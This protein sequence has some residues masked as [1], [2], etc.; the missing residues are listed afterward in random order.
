[1]FS[2]PCLIL[3]ALCSGTVFWYRLKSQ[4]LQRQLSN[5]SNKIESLSLQLREPANK[6]PEKRVTDGSTPTDP[7]GYA[8][9]I[10][11]AT[12]SKSIDADIA[13]IRKAEAQMSRYFANMPGFA[14]TLH[15]S[16]SGHQGF[17]FAGPGIEDMY[18]L[19]P[20]EVRHD[21]TPM[22]DRIHPD[23]RPLIEEALAKAV[24]NS[25]P[26]QLEFRVRKPGS[27]ER[28][29]ECRT[30]PE[31]QSNGETL[32]HGVS[33]DITERKEAE[34]KLKETLELIGGVISAIPDL[35]FEVDAEGRYLNIWTHTPE[36]L[37]AQR[38]DLLGRTLQE[39]MSPESAA[40]GMEALREAE[41]N[42]LSFG[43]VIRLDLPQGE[44]WF[45]LSVSKKPCTE[46]TAPRFL[47]LSRDVTGRKSMEAALAERE[48][49]FRSLAESSPDAIIRYDLEHRI[50]Y[51][52]RR[53]LDV[54]NLGSTD[55][56]IGRTPME[57]WPDGRFA[58]IDEAAA[59]AIANGV[60]QKI[61][62]ISKDDEK[63]TRVDQIVI[64]PERD[65][66]GEII[67]TL[68]FGRN[69]TSIREAERQLRHFIANFPG[70]AFT[71]RQTS[72]GRLC[73]PFISATVEEYCGVTP[74]EAMADFSALYD[75]IHPDDRQLVSATIAK[76][77]RTL[78]ITRLECRIC[79]PDLPERWIDLQS[80]PERQTNG[81]LLWYGIMLDITERKAMESAREKALIEAMRLVRTR[82]AF[83]S[84]VSHELRTPLNG[85]LGYTQLLQKSAN[86]NDQQHAELKVIEQS[87]EHLLSLIN[88]ILDHSKLEADRLELE[89]N[90]IP[91]AAFL[92]K[93]IA[94]VR[95]KLE[96]KHLAFFF[97]TITA[98]PATI[99]SDEK[100]LRQ[101]LLNLLGNAAKFTQKGTVSLLVE[102]PT[103]RRLRF[104]IRDTGIG[105]DHE[106]LQRIFQPFEQSGRS[107]HAEGTGLGLAIS[108]K[109]AHLMNGDISVESKLNKGSTFIFEMDM[110]TASTEQMET[111]MISALRTDET[112]PPRVPV[113]APP[114]TELNILLDL[115]QRG[116][117]RKIIRQANYL[118]ELNAEYA[119]FSDE[120]K[121]M[122]ETY[123]SRA[124]LDFINNYFEVN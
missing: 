34:H 64:L 33:L 68:A 31:P 52:N 60:P 63:E 94:M 95:P 10:L 105:I 83:M 1:M 66:N 28:W 36:L 23:D 53:L 4:R 48:Q 85:I 2:F 45:E 87:G 111:N 115:A 114:R 124:I 16:A 71:L 73:F 38:E 27:P 74:E 116:N 88:D 89:L 69:V 76:A 90:D 104:H 11:E 49:E 103:N 13:E 113:T 51:L 67:G 42:E 96:E 46:E 47:V 109:L 43:K 79:P 5:F 99:R 80:A 81:S 57:I 18:G 110:V 122:A 8:V 21:A 29:I 32:C 78:D 40:T 9:K 54:L 72:D 26:F 107:G 100:R 35:L 92:E 20:E 56:V 15:I 59:Q 102:V 75:Q 50:V 82:E 44:R 14:H 62:L 97:E 6:A 39:V 25:Q 3:V 58:A 120:L 65:V 123:Q 101:I 98:L 17:T 112:A 22:F 19:H 12:Q 119:P 70:V 91:L 93:L 121:Q 84:Q 55:E 61:E 41:V 108:L 24:E 30:M 7:D 86:L 117:M 118:K 106:N 77:A 37:A